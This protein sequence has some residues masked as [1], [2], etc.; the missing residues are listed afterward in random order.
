M[1]I[2]AQMGMN[3]SPD[4]S[5]GNLAHKKISYADP[6]EPWVKR[7]FIRIIE[8]LTGQP[9]IQKLYN[10]LQQEWVPE[11]GI[12]KAALEKLAVSPAFDPR[13]LEKVPAEGPIIFI[14]NHPFGVVDGLILGYLISMCRKEFVVLVNEAICN[15]DP[16]MD[17]Y[18][19]PI[20]FKETKEA[21]QT[22]IQ[23]RKTAM[24]KL[25]EGHSIGIFPA[26]GVATSPKGLGK[27]E[28]LEWKRFTA[29]MIQTA[30]ATVIPIYFHGQ[31]SRLFQL[32]SQV[33]VTLRLGMLL[34]EVRNKMG[35]SVQI[36]IGAPIPYEELAQ[37][38]DR[39]K[40]LEYLRNKTFQLSNL[41]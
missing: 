35:A 16:R 23:T 21:L 28:D 31:N 5:R 29:K 15:Q 25:K 9:K 13:Q 18:L 40:I 36:K 24:E 37:I 38:K 17:P 8:I 4:A 22:N 30:R 19:L 10:E 27:A 2:P 39:Q 12:W 33:S 11:G 7:V 41:P 20:D 26:G 14:A 3:G 6:G 34:N 32:V 1:E